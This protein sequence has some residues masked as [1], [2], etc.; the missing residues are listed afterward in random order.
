MHVAEMS[1]EG[2]SRAE[3]SRAFATA[4]TATLRSAGIAIT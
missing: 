1:N 4:C 2:R 3:G